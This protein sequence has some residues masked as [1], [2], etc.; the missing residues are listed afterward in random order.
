[1]LGKQ[2]EL[3]LELDSYHAIPGQ[4]SLRFILFPCDRIAILARCFISLILL[5][6]D[7]K[8]DNS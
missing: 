5:V 8:I 7:T 2:F 3:D 4:T 1:M 6:S